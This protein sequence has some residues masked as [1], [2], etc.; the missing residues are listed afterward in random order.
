MKR[1]MLVSMVLVSVLPAGA[2]E[3]VVD[4]AHPAASDQGPGSEARPWA[5]LAHAAEAA[6][7]G[8]TVR[9]L[10]GVYPG[11]LRPAR[12]GTDG[13]PIRFIGIADGD[14]RPII[15]GGDPGVD[16]R[17]RAWIRLEG[18]EIRH[19]DGTGVQ[20]DQ[21][22]HL[23]IVANHIHH[24]A[25]TGVRIPRGSD[26]LIDANSIHHLGVQGI[27]GG[28]WT[29]DIDRCTFSRNRIHTNQ[30]EDGIQLGSGHD[31][32]VAYN[33][34]HDI[35]S[36][37]PSHTDAIEIHSD[38]TNYR[39]I[40]NVMHNIRSEALMIEGNERRGGVGAPWV[41][42]NIISDGG[43]V[44]LQLSWTPRKAP[45]GSA[46]H[47][48]VARHNTVI[49]GRYHGVKVGAKA[50][51]ATVTAN[52]LACPEGGVR[53]YVEDDADAPTVDYNLSPIRRWTTGPHFIKADPM[54]VD[55][56]SP[57]SDTPPNVRLRPDSPAIDAGPGGSDIGAMAYPN[58]YVVDA[59]HA[60]AT[61]ALY[62]YPG[63][64]FRTIGRAVAV[65]RPGETIV[66]RGGVYRETIRPTVDDLTIRA[67]EGARVVVSGADRITGWR[68]DGDRWRAAVAERP[69][70]ILR[71]GAPTD[72]W[73]YDAQAGQL[74]VDGGDPRLHP[75]EVVVRALAVDRSA[76]EDLTVE[77]L[78]E[79]P[80]RP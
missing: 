69:T 3:Y 65:A 22:D 10:P 11:P 35:Q 67:A 48:A 54:F 61:D 15:E 77:G 60:G 16:L 52:I 40:G 47:R 70:D 27:Q 57:G 7:P 55:P 72:A 56:K 8:D 6:A 53:S 36:P 2:G 29:Y 4:P 26:C 19:A 50:H 1:W 58:V 74:I 59:T 24:T 71:D 79:G 44:P 45:E 73:R 51:A 43:G 68:R 34:L 63:L 64:P 18:F 76:C 41:E 46:Y 42:G 21:G 20:M 80:L 30:V 12:S 14:A 37:P 23:E 13:R 38:N 28:G 39:I 5:T 9:V 62:G 33:Y 66:V 25:G 75:I 17:R 49:G 32:V 31:C 78:T